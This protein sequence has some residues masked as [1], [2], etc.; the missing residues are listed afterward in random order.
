MKEY[1]KKLEN[2]TEAKCAYERNMETCMLEQLYFINRSKQII[3][4]LKD[5]KDFCVDSKY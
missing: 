1:E 3:H 2:Y 5:S 4:K